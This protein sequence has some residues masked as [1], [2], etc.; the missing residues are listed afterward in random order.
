MGLFEFYKKEIYDHG[1]FLGQRD[2]RYHT[3]HS[4]ISKDIYFN[5]EVDFFICEDYYGRYIGGIEDW[6][7]EDKKFLEVLGFTPEDFEQE[8][9]EL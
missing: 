9:L 8:E 7:E 2:I 6:S 5:D 3:D 1:Y 4:D